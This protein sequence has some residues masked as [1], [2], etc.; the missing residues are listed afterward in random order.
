M[1]PACYPPYPLLHL[2]R[3]SDCWPHLFLE[4][5][6]DQNVI[7]IQRTLLRLPDVIA[8]TGL[9]KSTIYRLIAAGEFP[10]PRKLGQRAVAWKA[11][12]I[13]E[14]ESSLPVAA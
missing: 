7:P 13:A 1:V 4:A 9:S 10:S 11:S 2:G 14:W 8:R 3:T 12:E 5:M 6:S